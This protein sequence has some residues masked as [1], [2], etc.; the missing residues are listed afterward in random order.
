MASAMTTEAT[1]AREADHEDLDR[2]GAHGADRGPHLTLVPDERRDE[3]A[4]EQDESDF[5]SFGIAILLGV[6]IG[7]PVLAALVAAAVRIAAPETEP[8]AIAGI[9][10]WVSLFCGPFLAGTVTVGL[11][12]SRHH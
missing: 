11:W 7:I 1:G 2:S 9:A 8:L 10:L 5:R 6:L 3:A 12:S 4:V